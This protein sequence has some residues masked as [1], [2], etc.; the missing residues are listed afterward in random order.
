MG[1]LC[2]C[3]NRHHG[4]HHTVLHAIPCSSSIL[5]TAGIALSAAMTGVTGIPERPQK[6][7]SVRDGALLGAGMLFASGMLRPLCKWEA[8]QP[9]MDPCATHILKSRANFSSCADGKKPDWPCLA[10]LHPGA[11]FFYRR[12]QT[13]PF[14]AG[15]T[16]FYV[17]SSALLHGIK[18][19]CSPTLKRERGCSRHLGSW[20]S[21]GMSH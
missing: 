13:V 17:R 18:P 8:C 21:C 15:S 12:K 14:K 7:L 3:C 19:A 1:M 6:H 10:C 2:P 9:L 11:T 16:I 5:T 4:N 20:S